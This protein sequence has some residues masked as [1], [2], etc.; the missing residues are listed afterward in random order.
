VAVAASLAEATRV[1]TAQDGSLELRQ[2]Q[3]LLDM[4]KE[5][6]SMIIVYP[7]DSFMGQQIAAASAGAGSRKNNLS[8]QASSS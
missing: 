2:I 8:P 7:A 6:S 5:E 3:A 4:S 1:L